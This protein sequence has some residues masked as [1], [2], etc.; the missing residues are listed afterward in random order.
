[1][2]EELKGVVVVGKDGSEIATAQDF[3]P[4]MSGGFTLQEVQVM[5]ATDQ[6]AVNAVR[7]LSSPVLS[8]SVERYDA[9]KI[10]E[11]MCSNG[12]KK[13]VIPIGYEDQIFD[14]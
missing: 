12:C 11:S 4:G 7:N 14:A 10:M 1:M 6:L 9:R 5:R 13:H 2:S 3:N 8:N